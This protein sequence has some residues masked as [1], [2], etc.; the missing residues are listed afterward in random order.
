MFVKY[1]KSIFISDLHIPF[2]DKNAVMIL[3]G[4]LRW[5]SPKYVFLVGDIIDFY[6]ISTFDKNPEREN[7]LQNDID[8]T[9][10]FLIDIRII[11]PNAKIVY[12]E[13]NHEN[14]LLRYLWKHPE[15]ANLRA[16]SIEN[17]L[18][19]EDMNIEY[20]NCKESCIFH[21]FSI[22]HGDLV[23]K[24]SGYTAKSQMEKRGISGLSGHSHRLSMHYMTNMSGELVWVENGCLCTKDQE[25]LIGIP[26]WQQGW[27]VGY[28]DGEKFSIEQV[29]IS[30]G[31]AEY[32]G[33]DF[34]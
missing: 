13:G 26:N 18:N 10:E 23:R 6:N 2:E 20:K 25:Y 29:C 31:R 3:K 16:L 21:G 24:F 8:R 14:R 33:R 17:L 4:F 27:S 9:F 7:R 15:I 19:L 30:N 12:L 5:F 34:R 32:A 28:W 1:E 11:C 22:E